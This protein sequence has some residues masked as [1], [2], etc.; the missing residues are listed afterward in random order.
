M[1]R[2]IRGLA[3]GGEF[4][5]LAADTTDVIEEAR[6]RHGLSP[7]ATAAL[8]RAMT[9]AVLLAFLL[10][11]TPRERLTLRV[12][13]DGPLGGIVVE[14]APDGSVRGYVKNPQAEV[15]LRSDGKLNVGELVGAGELRVVRA[16]PSGELYESSVPLVSGEIA[17]DLAHYLWQSEQIP[18]AVLLGVRVHGEGEVEVAGGMAVQ[19]L[20][21]ADEVDIQRLEQ[22]LA[23]IK[24]FTPLLKAKGLEGAVDAVMDGLG[25]ET[26]DLKPFGYAGNEVPV[27]F[28]CRCSRERAVEALVFF[29]PEEREDMIVQDGGAE[30]ICHWCG[31]VYRITPEEI[32]G[33]RVE[34]E[35]R[36]PDCGEIWYRRRADGLELEIPGDTCRCGRK[37]E[38]PEEPEPPQA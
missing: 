37:V 19:V 23:G 15:P 1:G 31:E 8:G 22:N 36:C 24:G 2:L 14:A 17:E 20:P 26:L 5:I 35:V 38:L 33:L 3:G 7:T 12:D 13:G 32:Q 4:R 29:T 10:S 28:R 11:K 16:L 25:F 34:H 6:R 27:A 30:V 18:S 21:G 9:G